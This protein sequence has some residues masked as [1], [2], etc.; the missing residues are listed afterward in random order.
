[1]LLLKHKVMLIVVFPM[2][3]LAA[4]QFYS[5]DHVFNVISEVRAQIFVESAKEVKYANDVQ[6]L[7]SLMSSTLFEIDNAFE[8]GNTAA[9]DQSVRLYRET[10][11]SRYFALQKL[12]ETLSEGGDY[13]FS[14]IVV[15]DTN[16]LAEFT[17][18][19]N[20]IRELDE[21]N[22]KFIS[23][24]IRA[25]DS[26]SVELEKYEHIE[27]S[28]ALTREI[29]GD[30][31]GFTNK[32]YIRVDEASK[33]VSVSEKDARDTLIMICAL[34]YT[35]AAFI[36]IFFYFLIIAPLERFTRAIDRKSMDGMAWIALEPEREDEIG[37]I[38]RALNEFLQ[39]KHRGRKSKNKKEKKSRKR[40]TSGKNGSGK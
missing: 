11:L 15:L 12:K 1:M 4:Y 40:L 6:Y 22:E 37:I 8:T 36:I 19:E 39:I 14:F 10:H 23:S 2:L 20:K 24:V 17:K 18:I 33:L 3:L 32:R 30:L 5:V 16:K 25:S 35:L 27:K 28:N 31:A 7:T 21:H 38:Y 29:V 9:L 13:A 34:G 26:N